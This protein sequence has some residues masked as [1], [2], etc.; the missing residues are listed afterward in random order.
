MSAFITFLPI[1]ISVF[2]FDGFVWYWILEYLVAIFIIVSVCTVS[3]VTQC[4]GITRRIGITLGYATFVIIKVLPP[5]IGQTWG[6]S[7]DSSVDN[8]GSPLE[9]CARV[10]SR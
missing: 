2:F 9:V 10:A 8:P 7:F 1:E 4:Y 3:L 6:D 5:I